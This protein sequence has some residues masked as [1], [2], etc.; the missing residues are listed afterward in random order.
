VPYDSD[1][2]IAHLAT[3]AVAMV[4]DVCGNAA[5]GFKIASIANRDS[6][7]NFVAIMSTSRDIRISRLE[8]AIL[9]F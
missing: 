2:H 4:D 7:W 5:V 3:L 8:A 6:R 9:D 1:M